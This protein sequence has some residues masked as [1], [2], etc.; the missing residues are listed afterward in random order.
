MFSYMLAAAFDDA[1]EDAFDELND[2]DYL[3]ES[4]HMSMKYL[5]RFLLPVTNDEFLFISL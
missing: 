4:L 1:D 5:F 2:N 3:S